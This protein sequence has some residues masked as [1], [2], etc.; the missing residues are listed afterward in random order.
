[1]GSSSEAPSEQAGPLPAP[2][3]QC[4]GTQHRCMIQKHTSSAFDVKAESVLELFGATHDSWLL[5]V[6]HNI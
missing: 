3:V 4:Q 6:L 1:M 5:D 2:D